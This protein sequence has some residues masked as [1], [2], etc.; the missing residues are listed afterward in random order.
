MACSKV[1]VSSSSSQDNRSLSP[2]ELDTNSL[3]EALRTWQER[4]H[5]IRTWDQLSQ[6][7]RSNIMRDAQ[8]L[9]DNAKKK[10]STTAPHW[11]V[12]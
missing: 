7:E 5:D 6:A 8:K 12:A 9:K 1:S 11:S 10:P 2:K 4:N 3:H